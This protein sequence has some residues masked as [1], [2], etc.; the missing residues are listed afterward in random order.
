MN[1][2]ESEE[3]NALRMKKHRTVEE[4]E[5]YRKLLEMFFEETLYH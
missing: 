1:E 5:K 3:M 4:D 2:K